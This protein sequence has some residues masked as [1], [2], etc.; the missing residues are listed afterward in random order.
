MVPLSSRSGLNST[1]GTSGYLDTT[2]STCTTTTRQGGR[3]AGASQSPALALGREGA[4]GGPSAGMVK[5]P[6]GLLRARFA[7]DS[8]HV[9]GG[10]VV[11]IG[12]CVR[13]LRMTGSAGLLAGST[14][15]RISSS[16]LTAFGPSPEKL[17]LAGT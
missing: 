11:G 4:A 17:T 14:K 9:S 5:G 16:A 8:G 12:W 15:N 2:S 13:A 1:T 7:A 10:R 6:W 3:Q